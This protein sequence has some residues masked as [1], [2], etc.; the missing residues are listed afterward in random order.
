MSSFLA[1]GNNYFVVEIVLLLGR[2]NG[3]ECVGDR[4]CV[5]WRRIEGNWL[6]LWQ[7]SRNLTKVDLEVEI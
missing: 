7:T 2:L 1:T 5:F 3:E 6:N 4:N